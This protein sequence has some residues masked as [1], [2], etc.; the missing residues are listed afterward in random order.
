[1]AQSDF[2]KKIVRSGLSNDQENLKKTVLELIEHSKKTN[3]GNLAISLQHIYK[4]FQNIQTTNSSLKQQPS[5]FELKESSQG[6]QEFV[7]ETLNSKYSLKDL[8]CEEEVSQVLQ[9]FIEE[10]LHIDLLKNFELPVSNKLLLHGP[11]GC[12]KTLTAFVIAG[13]LKKPLIVLNIGAIVSSKL[14]ETSKNLSKIF[15]RVAS[16]EC[17]LFMDEFD[18]LGRVRDFNQDHAEMKRVVNTLLQL[19]DYLPSHV[20]FIAATNYIQVIDHALFRRFDIKVELPLPKSFQIK[21]LINKTLQSDLF[22]LD[23]QIPLT[24]ITKAAEGLSYF[25]VQRSLINSI[26]RNLISKSVSN[27]KDHTKVNTKLWL[28]FIKKEKKE[29]NQ[30]LGI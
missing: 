29:K 7:I 9:Q 4:N 27:S 26:K 1:M 5:S 14:G 21:E 3:K 25:S 17:I 30:N 28:D 23:K 10:Q 16:E 12:G 20:T 2:I 24:T 19:F 22:Q 13:E 11:S 18:G 15:Q 8:V 6:I